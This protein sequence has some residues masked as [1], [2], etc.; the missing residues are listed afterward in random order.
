MIIL[1]SFLIDYLQQ[2]KWQPD[3]GEAQSPI[4]I[5]TQDTITQ[6][7]ENAGLYFSFEKEVCNFNNNGQ[8]LQLLALGE[9]ILNGER[10]VLMQVHFHSEA[11]H[12]IDGQ[13][14]PLEGHFVY[15]N[16]NGELA[17][18]AVLFAEGEEN[19]EF[20][21]VL[22]E[23]DSENALMISAELL[24]PENKSYY[25]YTGSLT[26]PPLTENVKWFVLQE[27]LTVSTSQIEAFCA[28]HGKNRR[29]LQPLN[30]RTVFAYHC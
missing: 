4:A 10:H 18:V 14:F 27:N 9:A 26:T 25:H 16:G 24:L 3:G 22:A 21:Q 15:Q 2:E 8:N 6:T 28:L 30:Q 5:V 23:F 11:E 13:S 7:D 20:Q 29:Q 12:T 17:V 1:K 19:Q